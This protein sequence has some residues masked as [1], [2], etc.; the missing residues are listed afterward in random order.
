MHFYVPKSALKYF[1]SLFPANFQLPSLQIFLFCFYIPLSV[2]S[3][4]SVV[5]HPYE[6]PQEPESPTSPIFQALIL[7]THLFNYRPRTRTVLKIV[8]NRPLLCISNPCSPPRGLFFLLP[9]CQP[10]N[11]LFQQIQP[12]FSWGSKVVQKR[13]SRGFPNETPSLPSADS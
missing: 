2:K 8:E 13:N 9:T 3:T 12:P 4:F 5:A 7:V 10:L 11:L 1:A 6:V